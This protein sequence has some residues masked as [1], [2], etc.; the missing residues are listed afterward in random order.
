MKGFTI[1]HRLSFLL[2][3]VS[4]IRSKK[5][6]L[7]INKTMLIW[8]RTRRSGLSGLSLEL[9]R[10]RFSDQ[11]FKRIQQSFDRQGF[12][13]VIGAKLHEVSKGECTIVLPYS[14]KITQQQDTFHGGAIG[15][16][17]DI[18][19]GYAGLTV[20]PPNSEVVT[21]EYKINFLASLKGGTLLAKGKVIKAG[22]RLIITE[23][24][25]FHHY[26]DGKETICAVLQQTLVPIIKTY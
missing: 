25:V 21:V 15:A 13:K 16:I 14:E 11:Y 9:G 8:R 10:R 26:D 19:A 2:P 6:L 18:A 23:A 17:A 3:T 22:K 4:T 20:A 1:Q 24:R 5:R 7:E 12:M